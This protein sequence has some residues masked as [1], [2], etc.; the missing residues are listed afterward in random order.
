MKKKK[1]S[2]QNSLAKPKKIITSLAAQAAQTLKF[3]LSNVAFRQTAYK[4]GQY[5]YYYF[6]SSRIF[7]FCNDFFC[8]NP[9]THLF[10]QFLQFTKMKEE[11]IFKNVAFQ[12]YFLLQ[13]SWKESIKMGPKDSQSSI[14]IFS[15]GYFLSV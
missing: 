12:Q 1:T 7:F 11:K 13:I 5:N 8:Q 15:T 6:K 14:S 9:H 10:P 2:K 4:T 3:T